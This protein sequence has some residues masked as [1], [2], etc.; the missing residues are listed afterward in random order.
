MARWRKSTHSGANDN[1]DCVEIDF[2]GPTAA[3]RDSKNPGQTLVVSVE[4]FRAFV[5]SARRNAE[6]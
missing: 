1:S 6:I 3:L 2:A 4:T 5:A